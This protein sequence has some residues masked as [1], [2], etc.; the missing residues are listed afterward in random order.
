MYARARN[1]C[2]VLYR[3]S[4]PYISLVGFR[5]T[6]NS[7]RSTGGAKDHHESAILLSPYCCPLLC[8]FHVYYTLNPLV[9]NGAH[10]PKTV[11]CPWFGT[12]Y[13][14]QC[15]L[16]HFQPFLMTLISP[17][18]HY[19]VLHICAR[20]FCMYACTCV[21]V[22]CNFPSKQANE[23]RRGER[24]G[25]EETPEA[26]RERRRRSGRM[27]PPKNAFPP[28]ILSPLSSLSSFFECR[29]TGLLACVCVC[30]WWGHTTAFPSSL[31][32]PPP[33]LPVSAPFGARSSFSA[34]MPLSLA[35]DSLRH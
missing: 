30:A 35:F 6:H 10:S 25:E 1:R 11:V 4:P 15:R 21:Y 33:P 29:P 12:C 14:R 7:R 2:C 24:R 16:T 9:L 18:M 8:V 32:P 23:H 28:L 26:T 20:V 5:C 19:L 31:L 3:E 13:T 27:P 22:C 17:P 34:S